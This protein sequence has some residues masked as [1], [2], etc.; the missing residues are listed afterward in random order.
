MDDCAIER[1][2]LTLED[3]A[4]HLAS[5]SKAK[6]DFRVGSEHEKFLFR[7]G[8]HDTVGYGPD[9]EG[10]GGVQALLEGLMK[11]GWHGVYEDSA[12]GHT[13]IALQRGQAQPSEVCYAT[14]SKF[15]Q[16]FQLRSLEDL[17]R[18]QDLQKL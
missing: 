17:P 4:G 15:L 12:A 2:A 18:T 7:T 16:L 6:A 1:R 14:T 9:A 8:T 10:R 5:G 13:L 3:M 11:F